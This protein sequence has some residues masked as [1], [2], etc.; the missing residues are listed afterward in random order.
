M[1]ARLAW[2]NLLIAST[3]V[4]TSSSD[5]TGYIHG[6]LANPARWKRWQSGTST[7]DQ[8]AKFD[9]GFNQTLRV[10]A[11]IDPVLHPGGT[12]KLQAH[13]SDVWTSP[14]IDVTVAVPAV[15]YSGVVSTWIVAGSSLR[16]VRFYFTNVTTTSSA[17]SLGAAFAGSYLEPYRSLSKELSVRR[18]DPS[19]Q[20]YAM[21]GQR[22][23][24]R[25]PKYHEVNGRFVLQKATAR[26]DLRQVFETVGATGSVI[27]AVDPNDTSLVFYGSLASALQAQHMGSDLWDVPIDFVEDV[28]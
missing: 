28:A 12:L 14:T 16:W 8:W 25:L 15:N 19:V 13:T 4:I 24:L 3:A 26:N 2:N 9:L 10:I 7:S 17:V 1:G 5:A 23:S 6:N 11:A 22:S 27:L 20:R 21:G 18:V